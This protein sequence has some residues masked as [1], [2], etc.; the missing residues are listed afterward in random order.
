MKVH[1]LMLGLTLMIAATVSQAFIGEVTGEVSIIRSH[2]S[3]VS[4]DWMSL[5]TVTSAGSCTTYGGLAIFYFREDEH[6]KRQ[7]SMALAAKMASKKV[8]IGYDDV[9]LRN[10][11][12]LIRYIDIFE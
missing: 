9:N 7:I 8:V 6:A 10:G 5:K 2:D 12:C 11:G 1:S 3:T 4:T